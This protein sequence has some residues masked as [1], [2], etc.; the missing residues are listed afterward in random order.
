MRGQAK[1]VP[2]WDGIRNIASC[3]GPMCK[4]KYYN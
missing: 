1:G 4:F 2:T 3:Y